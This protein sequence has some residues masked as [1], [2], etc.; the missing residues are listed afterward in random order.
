MP[1]DVIPRVYWDILGD[2]GILYIFIYIY[3]GL[4]ERG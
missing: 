3:I 4:C 2:I 1:T